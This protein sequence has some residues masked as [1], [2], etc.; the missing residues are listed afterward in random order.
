MIFFGRRDGERDPA[1]DFQLQ[2]LSALVVDFE[3]VRDSASPEILA[4]G[5]A[6]ILDRWALA[7]RPTPCLAGLSTGHPSLP[8]ENR[9]IGTSAI[10]LMSQDR[11][12]ARAL[13][14]WYQLG[15]PAEHPGDH[16]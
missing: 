6:P 10:W 7:L 12:W 16:A 11:T 1:F 13:S 8:G 14:R 9:E 15:R 4:H 5:R 3:R 2:R